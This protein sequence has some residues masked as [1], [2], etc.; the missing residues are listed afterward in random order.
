MQVNL[1]VLINVKSVPAST[2]SK[3]TS[4]PSS[5]FHHTANHPSSSVGSSLNNTSRI[6]AALSPALGR[7][8]GWNGFGRVFAMCSK[9]M[10]SIGAAGSSAM[11][12]AQKMCARLMKTE[13]SATWLPGQELGWVCE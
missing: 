4:T 5:S 1:V 13:R 9:A 3:V 2:R 8:I 6:L 11:S 7:I 12:R 10:L